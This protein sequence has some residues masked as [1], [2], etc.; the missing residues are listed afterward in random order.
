MHLGERRGAPRHKF[1][2]PAHALNVD[3]VGIL[4]HREMSQKCFKNRTKGNSGKINYVAVKN[5]S[6]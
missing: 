6:F 1:D 3:V 2:A 5:A 4:K